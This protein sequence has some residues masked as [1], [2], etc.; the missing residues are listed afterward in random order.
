MWGVFD[1]G[2]VWI[3][4]GGDNRVDLIE[5]TGRT[6]AGSSVPHAVIR[7]TDDDLRLWRGMPA[8]ATFDGV[9]RAIAPVKAPFQE[10]TGSAAG[11]LWFWLNQTAGYRQELYACR[12]GTDGETR[13][14]WLP[15]AHKIVAIGRRHLYVYGESR[16]MAS[17]R[18]A[19]IR[20]PCVT[21]TLPGKGN[22]TRVDFPGDS[23][24]RLD[25]AGRTGDIPWI[26]PSSRPAS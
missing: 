18:S 14:V 9:K 26:T 15:A 11:D 2:R 20:A 13:R 17:P 3:A 8:P 19:P 5:A 16:P 7:T 6:V 4:R 1:D 10:V 12:V 25:G 21:P 22:R 23:G 24:A